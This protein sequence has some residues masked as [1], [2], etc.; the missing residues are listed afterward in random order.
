MTRAHIVGAVAFA[1]VG[2]CLIATGGCEAI[3]SDNLPTG[4]CAPDNVQGGCPPGYICYQGQCA[5]MAPQAGGAGGGGGGGGGGRDA[6]GGGGG[7]AGGGGGGGGGG[8][9]GAGGGGGGAGGGGGGGGVDAGCVGGGGSCS[10]FGDCCSKICGDEN[11]LGQ[12]VYTSAGSHN[13]CTAPCCTSDD[14]AAG[15]VC[16]AP[17]T[18]SNYCVDP[19]WIG[20][21]PPQSSPGAI[22]T[23]CTTGS[24]CRSGICDTT[25]GACTDTCCAT[26]SCGAGINCQLSTFPGAV[27]VDDH[28]TWS[29]KA[30]PQSGGPQAVC[31]QDT[32]C[33]SNKCISFN[34]TN[35]ECVQACRN[36]PSCPSQYV[37]APTILINGADGGIENNGDAFAACFF[38]T[39]PPGSG[40]TGSACSGASAD[41]ACRSNSCDTAQSVCSD[42]CFADA[43]CTGLVCRSLFV[44][45]Q[46]GGN[47]EILACQNP[48]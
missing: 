40:A 38:Q 34:G 9:G 31:G 41:A 8:A 22:G 3:V 5:F 47:N 19:R 43:D 1:L 29:C 18:G 26:S 35:G 21:Q 7:G 39:P 25:A 32:D 48:T 13:V 12:A 30:T 36:S 23:P 45:V 16:Y 37:C 24:Q 4:S 27:N 44:K 15:L 42:M 2:A 14:C 10:G 11:A 17:G 28:F 33:A 6:G 46:G 20:R